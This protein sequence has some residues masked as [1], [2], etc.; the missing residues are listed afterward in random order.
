MGTHL[1]MIVSRTKFQ[2]VILRRSSK[3]T[4]GTQNSGGDVMRKG[5]EFGCVLKFGCYSDSFPYSYSNGEK[6]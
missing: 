4:V 5:R 3:P 1:P 6:R 2:G